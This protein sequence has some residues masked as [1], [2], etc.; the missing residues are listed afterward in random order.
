MVYVPGTNAMIARHAVYGPFKI[1]CGIG[2]GSSP[3]AFG[4]VVV[5]VV[6]R[7]VILFLLL[8]LVRIQVVGDHG[9]EDPVGDWLLLL[10]G[11]LTTPRE[12][13]GREVFLLAC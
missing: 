3:C 11:R 6:A 4:D 12:M 5:G 7:A 2:D 10:N 13:L 8:F 9:T 1:L